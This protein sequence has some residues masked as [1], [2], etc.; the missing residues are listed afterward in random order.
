VHALVFRP[1]ADLE[2][3][4][5]PVRLVDEMMT[6]PADRLK[7]RGVTRLER[8]LAVIL[9]QNDFAF[10]YNTNSSSCSCQW[11]SAEAA[12]GLSVVRLTPN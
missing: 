5:V 2:I 8:R 6:D 4:G 3:N 9:D 11:R 12:P 7:T 10:Q 1:G